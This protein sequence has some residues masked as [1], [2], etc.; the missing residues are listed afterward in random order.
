MSTCQ[1]VSVS[2]N[3]SSPAP[4]S[5]ENVPSKTETSET[6]NDLFAGPIRFPF[7]SRHQPHP[8]RVAH[9]RG[10]LDAPICH[11]ND[12]YA[13]QTAARQALLRGHRASQPIDSMATAHLTGLSPQYHTDFRLRQAPV[14]LVTEATIQAPSF[15][16]IP[17]ALAMLAQPRLRRPN[18]DTINSLQYFTGLRNF[19]V[20]ERP[21]IG[22]LAA[23]TTGSQTRLPA[24][25]EDPLIAWQPQKYKNYRS[26]PEHQDDQGAWRQSLKWFTN[27]I[28][29]ESNL[30]S[31][32]ATVFIFLSKPKQHL[33]SGL[34]VDLCSHGL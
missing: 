14:H 3:T 21:R 28:L 20:R 1:L 24:W 5:R 6:D 11:V 18:I 33:P 7:V 4:S 13:A 25:A 10:L 19:S 29:G 9:M 2:A 15:A 30:A 32:V 12:D 26:N 27:I 34:A 16:R 17:V 23:L 8:R 22:L 31:G